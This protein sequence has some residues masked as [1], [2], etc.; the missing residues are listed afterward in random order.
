[1]SKAIWQKAASSTCHPS[2][3]QMDSSDLDSRLIHG[4]SS[5]HKSVL[6]RHLD[7]FTHFCTTHPCPTQTHTHTD[8]ATCGIC[9]NRLHLCYACDAAHYNSNSFNHQVDTAFSPKSSLSQ[10]ITRGQ[11]SRIVQPQCSCVAHSD[12]FLPRTTR[13]W[14]VLPINPSTFHTVDAFKSYLNTKLSTRRCF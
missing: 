13:H 9:R 1:M 7:R 4:S 14:N 2:P 5:P 12:S 6:E 11:T 8:H 3:L 10:S